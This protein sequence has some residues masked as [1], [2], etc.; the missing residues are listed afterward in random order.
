[1]TNSILGAGEAVGPT[2]VRIA[3]VGKGVGRNVIGALVGNSVGFSVGLTDGTP[4]GFG[5]GDDVGTK[6]GDFVAL[7]G[8][9]DV[10]GEEVGV[11]VS[12]ER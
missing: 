5:V 10:V 2:A 9:T 8:A 12:K 6:A 4:V 3:L 11:S 7:V 1:M